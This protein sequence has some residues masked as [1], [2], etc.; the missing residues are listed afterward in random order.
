MAVSEFLTG[1]GYLYQGAWLGD[2]ELALKKVT[3]RLVDIEATEADAF[4]GRPFMRVITKSGAMF[5]VFQV[6]DPRPEPSTKV[7]DAAIIRPALTG[8]QESVAPKPR[9][10][11]YLPASISEKKGK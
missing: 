8:S 7:I 5:I 2:H 1:V 4:N 9:R 6:N 11:I 10:I 3:I